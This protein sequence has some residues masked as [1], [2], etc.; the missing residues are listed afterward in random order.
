MLRIT[1]AG[2][3]LP[4]FDDTRMPVAEG[5]ALEKVTGLTPPALW[6]GVE[7]FSPAAIL[8]LVWL[9][10]RRAGGE[11]ELRYS[12]LAFDLSDFDMVEID[13]DGRVIRRDPKT[14]AITHLDG[15]PV[16]RAA[17]GDDDPAG[18]VGLDPTRAEEAP[19]C[20]SNGSPS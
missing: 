20:S 18:E 11:A 5:I 6:E 12:K 1:V 3:T 8:A 2:D 16:D 14:K 15:Q 7:R 13:E 10:R 4:D 17:D 19:A 9:A